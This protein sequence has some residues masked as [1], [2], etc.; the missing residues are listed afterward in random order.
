[1]GR[2]TLVKG[3][4]SETL[5]ADAAERLEITKASLIMIDCDLYSSAKQALD[6]C[7]PLIGDVAVV[8]FD[9]WTLGRGDEDQNLGEQ[10]AWAEFLAESPSLTAEEVGTYFHTQ[11][12]PPVPSKIFRLTRMLRQ[13]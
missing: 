7:A 1:M 3:F 5:S 12:N 4:Y 2:V 6:F 10:R 11:V 13:A 9:D 8:F